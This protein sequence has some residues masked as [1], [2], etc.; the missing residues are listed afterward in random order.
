MLRIG[1]KQ[2]KIETL[3]KNPLFSFP[4]HLIFLQRL[5]LLNSKVSDCKI[6]GLG[7]E[8]EEDKVDLINLV[9]S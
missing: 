1:K 3:Y 2:I 8:S 7:E 9:N 5:S 4:S 6:H